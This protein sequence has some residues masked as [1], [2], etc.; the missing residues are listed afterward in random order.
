MG[1]NGSLGIARRYDRGCV[2]VGML[3]C[4]LMG[5]LEGVLMGL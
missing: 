3:E 1:V 5:M 2:L 4:V